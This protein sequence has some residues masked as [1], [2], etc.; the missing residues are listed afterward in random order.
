VSTLK[1]DVRQHFTLAHELGHY[2]LHQDILK[3]ENGLIDEDK[4]LD[5]GRMLYRLDDATYDRIERE[6]NHFAASLIMPNE[7]VRKAWAAT[8]SIQECARIFKVSNIAMSIRLT[9]LGLV[10]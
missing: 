10:Q 6:A 4:D 5:A 7:L 2:F 1:P 9:E 3:K 8:A